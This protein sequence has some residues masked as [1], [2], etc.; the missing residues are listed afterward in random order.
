MLLILCTRINPDEIPTEIK[1]AFQ[2]KF[3][4][5]TLEFRYINPATPE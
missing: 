2:D 4:G 5:E 1:K 3:A